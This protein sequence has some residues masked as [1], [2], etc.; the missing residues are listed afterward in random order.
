MKGERVSV[1]DID[2]EN[3]KKR[4]WEEKARE[5]IRKRGGERKRWEKRDGHLY[6][7]NIW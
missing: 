1:K 3:E 6:F 7:I 2:R 4:L 5:K